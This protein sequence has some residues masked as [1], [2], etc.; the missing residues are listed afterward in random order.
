M[1]TTS[2]FSRWQTTVGDGSGTFRGV[3]FNVKGEQGQNGGRRT[4]RREFPLRENGG[5]DDIGQRLRE[6]SFNA[7]VVGD[8][9]LTRRDALIKALDAPG[10]GELVHPNYGTLQVQVDSWSCKED[11]SGGGR[12]EFSVTFYPPLTTD[13]PISTADAA[14]KTQAATDKAKSG[15]FGDFADGWDISDLSLHDVQSLIDGATSY[16]NQI[17]STI[18]QYF[19]VLDDLSDIM[20]SAT[21]LQASLSGLIYEPASLAHQVDQLVGSV[22]GV[23]D[24]AGQA[25][26]AYSGMSN[27]TAYNSSTPA[28]VET[29]D[30]NGNAVPTTAAQ[31]S[32]PQGKAA[33]QQLSAMVTQTITLYQTSS[34]SSMMTEAVRLSGNSTREQ[35]AE[36]VAST[37]TNATAVTM[38]SQDDAQVMAEQMADELDVAAMTASELG[39][40]QAEDGLRRLRLSFITDITTR[41]KLLPDVQTVTVTTTEPALVLLN[42]VSGDVSGWDAFTLRNNVRNPLFL[43]AGNSYGIVNNGND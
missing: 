1:I 38:V 39:W 5:A 42:R 8:D 30:S 21:A 24:T 2:G 25:F 16:I 14:A 19:G 9:Y 40:P 43:M 33:S 12:A 20:S 18:Q 28:V 35:R 31:P 4:V 26:N 3:P 36:L 27:N 15:L 32:T 7:I 13:A 11:T 37:V 17:T 22:Q 23:S 41:S 34:A 6:Y 29:Q 10:P